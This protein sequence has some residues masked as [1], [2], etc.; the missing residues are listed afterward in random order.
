MISTVNPNSVHEWIF[1]PKG[2]TFQRIKRIWTRVQNYLAEKNPDPS[3]FYQYLQ[4]K[5]VL[6][7]PCEQATLDHLSTLQKSFVQ[8]TISKINKQESSYLVNELQDAPDFQYAFL[9]RLCALTKG[10]P[11]VLSIDTACFLGLIW[12]VEAILLPWPLTLKSFQTF[13]KAFLAVQ[14]TAIKRSILKKLYANPSLSPYLTYLK[15]HHFSTVYALFKLEVEQIAQEEHE[16]S[17][18]VQVRDLFVKFCLPEFLSSSLPLEIR[19]TGAGQWIRDLPQEIEK[20]PVSLRKYFK[21]IGLISKKEMLCNGLTPVETKQNFIN[22]LRLLERKCEFVQ[23]ASWKDE[24][25]SKESNIIETQIKN[26]RHFPDPLRLDLKWISG[27]SM[28]EQWEARDDL[29]FLYFSIVLSKTTLKKESFIESWIYEDRK[30]ME[31]YASRIDPSEVKAMMEEKIK[32]LYKELFEQEP[33]SHLTGY[34]LYLLFKKQWKILYGQVKNKVADPLYAAVAE[35]AYLYHDIKMMRAIEKDLSVFL[36]PSVQEIEELDGLSLAYQKVEEKIA[37]KNRKTS[38]YFNRNCLGLEPSFFQNIER[39]LLEVEDFTKK[40]PNSLVAEFFRSKNLIKGNAIN[41]NLNKLYLLRSFQSY[42][43]FLLYLLKIKAKKIGMQIP[44]KKWNLEEIESLYQ[45]IGPIDLEAIERDIKIDSSWPWDDFSGEKHPALYKVFNWL[46]VKWVGAWNLETNFL[47]KY[48]ILHWFIHSLK[49][50]I[51]EIFSPS[52]AQAK[53]SQ[54][55]E[56]VELCDLKGIND[57]AVE[58]F[59]AISK[60]SLLP[61]RKDSLKVALTPEIVCDF[62]PLLED[63]G[64]DWV[65]RS[66]FR[67]SIAIGKE[68]FPNLL[69]SYLKMSILST[70]LEVFYAKS[71]REIRRL[72]MPHVYEDLLQSAIAVRDTKA[73]DWIFQKIAYERYLTQLKDLSIKGLP[74]L[75]NPAWSISN[76]IQKTKVMLKGSSLDPETCNELLWTLDSFPAYLLRDL[77]QDEEAT[78]KTKGTAYINSVDETSKPLLSYMKKKGFVP[79]VWNKDEIRDLCELYREF[80]DQKIREVEQDTAVWKKGLIADLENLSF[81]DPERLDQIVD[82]LRSQTIEEFVVKS[83]NFRLIYSLKWIFSQDCPSLEKFM[84]AFNRP[85]NAVN[86]KTILQS[87]F[88]SKEL[89]PYSQHLMDNGGIQAGYQALEAMVESGSMKNSNIYSMFF[90]NFLAS[91]EKETDFFE[92]AVS[93]RASIDE[94]TAWLNGEGKNS[95]LRKFFETQKMFNDRFLAFTSPSHVRKSII[96]CYELLKGINGFSVNAMS[97]LALNTAIQERAYLKFLASLPETSPCRA[98]YKRYIKK[99]ISWN[100]LVEQTDDPRLMEHLDRAIEITQES[101][102]DLFP[103]KTLKN[104]N[105]AIAVHISK[106]GLNRFSTVNLLEQYQDGMN[107]AA[108]LVFSIVQ[109]QTEPVFDASKIKLREFANTRDMDLLCEIVDDIVQFEQ[110]TTG[111]EK[112]IILK[113]LLPKWTE[114]VDSYRAWAKNLSPAHF[115]NPWKEGTELGIYELYRNMKDTQEFTFMILKIQIAA[116]N[117]PNPYSVLL[118]IAEQAENENY[119][120]WMTGKVL[121]ARYEKALQDAKESYDPSL[122]ALSKEVKGLPIEEK[123]ERTGQALSQKEGLFYKQLLATVNDLPWEFCS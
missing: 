12:N 9:D 52:E 37:N 21:R 6:S 23:D 40:R 90:H 119:I 109:K 116:L 65:H 59:T 47:F 50:N 30:E 68:I 45:E 103:W 106:I 49:S 69:S 54:L 61:R 79:S 123:L 85:S 48:K 26:P 42:K 89:F 15:E 112:E 76:I 63:I 39:S 113:E 110:N 117:L 92:E 86:R 104:P 22:A 2:P 100:E 32:T 115:L 53:K 24:V 108:E 80:I 120:N 107:Y 93:S 122:D 35:E 43:H 46:E 16:I 83:S 66:S 14:D 73:C 11:Q 5:D 78:L 51:D 118:D 111:K 13:A 33:P 96:Q 75:Y 8:E 56:Y 70:A 71:L 36:I 10:H 74:S 38:S 62:T 31:T 17:K 97:F 67:N 57:A 64:W 88:S 41:P 101:V 72:K 55:D 7:L 4:E 34:E 82:V 19:A 29:E 60:S 20:I 102:Q 87:F 18:D 3:S 94:L 77:S 114:K 99:E 44:S 25:S 58:V 81:F 27:Y 28:L 84:E 95:L 121:Y 91:S 105:S 98:L 1:R